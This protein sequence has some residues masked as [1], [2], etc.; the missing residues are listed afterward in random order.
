MPSTSSAVKKAGVRGYGATVTECAPTLEAREATA[1]QVIEDER[2]RHQ[3][4]RVEFVPPYDDGKCDEGR[5]SVHFQTERSQ[6]TYSSLVR[7]IAG[8]ATISIE[9]LQQAKETDRPLDV[10]IAPVGGGGMLSGVA[11]A[12]KAIDPHIW[13]IGAEPRGADD[14]YRSFRSK[15]FQPSVN[16]QTIADGLLTSTGK[17]TFPLILRY[18]DAIHTVTEEEIKYVLTSFRRLHMAFC[19]LFYRRAMKFSF[20]RLKLV[21]EPS[22]AVPLAVALFSREFK[23]SVQARATSLGRTSLNI[24]VVFSGGNVDLSVVSGLFEGVQYDVQP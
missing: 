24:G 21:I 19:I 1:S 2:N 4:Q 3:D 6:Q 9:L 5:Y 22:A 17:L 11:L 7:I 23:G 18:V 8:Q 14:A 15:T 10:V 13:V 16:P 20:E 12:A